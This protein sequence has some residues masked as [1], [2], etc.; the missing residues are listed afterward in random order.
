MVT[1]IVLPIL[2]NKQTQRI[3]SAVSVVVMT[4]EIR[5]LNG[6]KQLRLFKRE[7]VHLLEACFVV[8]ESHTCVC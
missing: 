3:V 8:L 7:K 2:I 4:A 1:K 6:K 5:G